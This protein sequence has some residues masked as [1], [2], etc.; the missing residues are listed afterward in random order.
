MQ[1][2]DAGKLP[3]PHVSTQRAAVQPA[4]QCCFGAPNQPRSRRSESLLRQD[5]EGNNKR[6]HHAAERVC[7]RS[8]VCG[9]PAQRQQDMHT[10]GGEWMRAVGLAVGRTSYLPAA[11]SATAARP[12]PLLLLHLCT[13]EDLALLLHTC[14]CLA[15]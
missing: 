1:W 7:G 6:T 14:R 12:P 9:S 4:G 15:F 5:I 13:P 10:A 2:Q 8:A 3:S 11:A